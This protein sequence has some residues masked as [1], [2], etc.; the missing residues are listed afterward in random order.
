MAQI[1]SYPF[2]GIF[3]KEPLGFLGNNP[4]SDA[5]FAEYVFSILKAY[6]RRFKRKYVF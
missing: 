1:K 6:F 5:Y 3:L 2:E 4:Q